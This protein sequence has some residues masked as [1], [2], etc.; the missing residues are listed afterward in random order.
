MTRPL[1]HP[2]RHSAPRPARAG[3][4]QPVAAVLTDR[5]DDVVVAEAAARMAV[6]RRA[7]LLLIAV[8]PPRVKRSGL[9][10]SSVSVRAVLARVMPRVGPLHLGYIPEVFHLPPGNGPRLTAAR[11][12]LALAARHGAPDVVA[13]RRGP[14]GLDA[15]T[16]IEAAA[17][18]GGPFIHAIAPAAWVPL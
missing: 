10:P 4:V 5:I 7:P 15:H 11:G 9:G 1:S 14:H 8:M 17:L 3:L 13:A 6:A 2:S 16:L 12:L 18:R